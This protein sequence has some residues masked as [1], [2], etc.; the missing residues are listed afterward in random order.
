MTIEEFIAAL[1][2]APDGPARRALMDGHE[3]FLQVETVFALKERA[4][5][6]ER[7]DARQALMIGRV[8]EEVA[9]HTSKKDEACALALWTQANAHDFLAELDT[10]VRCYE[11]AAELF[12][13]ADKPLDAARTGIGQ[14]LTLMKMGQFEKAQTLAESIRSVFVRQEDV[15]SLAKVDMNLGTLHTQQGQYALA[16]DDFKRA[17]QAFQSLG[18]PLY[19][20]MDQINQANMLNELDEFLEA[21]RLHELARPVFETGGL[22]TTAASVDLD[23][24]ILQYARGNY[25]KSF[26]TFE[27]ARAAF[28]SLSTQV[29]LAV[30]DLEES[31]LHLDLNLPE[32]ALRLAMQAEKAFAE[33]GMPFE[34]ARAR[35]NHA[36]ALA[37]LGQGEEAAALLQQA[38]DLFAAQGNET[39]LAHTDLQRAEVIGKSGQ[40]A[41]AKTLA[42]EAA[43]AYAHLGMKTKQA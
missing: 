34:M 25:T 26:N 2:S 22:R 41:A 39:W 40:R 9:Q 18:D 11:R 15:L 12:R 43:K 19:A 17:T 31:D 28:T 21:E 13:A 27:R 38:R 8:A 29:N 37:R 6:L 14:M 30:T 5:R 7:D 10:A 35:A 16:L 23:L 1:L 42:S 33:I 24:A 3:K 36:V 20:A 4:D 32:T